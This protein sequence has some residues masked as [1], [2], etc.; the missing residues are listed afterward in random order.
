MERRGAE[1]C[2]T[3]QRKTIMTMDCKIVIPDS[4]YHDDVVEYMAIRYGLPPREVI[5][6]FLCQEGIISKPEDTGFPL[7]AENEMAILRDMGLRHSC[8]KFNDKL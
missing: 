1:K 3:L 7:F 2:L 5:S 8:I 4:I 6:H